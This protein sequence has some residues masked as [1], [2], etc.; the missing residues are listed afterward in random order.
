MK[1]HTTLLLFLASLAAATSL[2]TT[3]DNLTA[4]TINCDTCKERYEFCNKVRSFDPLS[5]RRRRLSTH[6]VRPHAGPGGLPAN[7]S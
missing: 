2:E 7:V 5:P 3:G 6:T 4:T 1:L